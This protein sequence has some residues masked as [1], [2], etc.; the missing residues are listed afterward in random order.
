MRWFPLSLFRKYPATGVAA[1]AAMLVAGFLIFAYSPSQPEKVVAGDGTAAPP[2]SGAGNAASASG[3]VST[4]E[5]GGRNDTGP[6]VSV[7]GHTPHDWP[8]KP[9]AKSLNGTQIDGQLRADANGNLIVD[10]KVKDFFDYFLSAV[11]E[12][13]PEVAVA[14]M[15]KLARASLP[16]KAVNQAMTLLGQYLDYKEKALNFSRQKLSVPPDKQGMS[17]QISMLRKGLKRLNELQN[18]TMPPEA[19]KAFF[20]AQQAYG[21]YVLKSLEIQQRQDLTPSEKAQMIANARDQLPPIIAHTQQQLAENQNQMQQIQHIEDTAASPDEAA[22]QLE[23]LGVS[24]DRISRIVGYMNRKT[25]FAKQYQA[26]AQD[27]RRLKNASLAPDD[28][29]QQKNQLLHQ[30]FSDSEERTWAKLKD[31]APTDPKIKN[32]ASL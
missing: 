10:L 14:E 16:P 31:M 8:G 6:A 22:V 2:S 28:F 21:H 23:Q 13:K 4:A 1:F 11:G 26:Y 29:A 12:V 19:V 7:P 15:E 30:Y 24:Q 27:L 20:G 9:F 25:D 3:K 5:T 18:E 32:K 17:Y